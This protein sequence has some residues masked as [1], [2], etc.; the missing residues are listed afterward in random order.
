MGGNRDA[1]AS[2]PSFRDSMVPGPGD[3]RC[4]V[5]ETFA[6]TGEV[7]HSRPLPVRGEGRD[8]F[9]LRPGMRVDWRCIHNV[10]KPMRSNLRRYLKHGILPQLQ[11]FEAVSRYESCTRAADELCMAQPTV[12]VQLRKLT[13]T[14]G[15][16]LFE[17]V[18]RRMCVTEAGH[19]LYSASADIFARLQQL[20]DAFA[21]MRGLRTGSLRLAVGTA[22]KYLAPRMLAG[23][24]NQ[25]PGVEVFLQIHNREMLLRRLAENVD[26]LYIFADP[27]DGEVISQSILPNSMVVFARAD[28]P[29]A[30]Q[31]AIAF[32]RFAEEWFIIREPGSG[33]RML[34]NNIFAA[35]GRKPRVRA[36][37]STNEAIQQGILAGLGVSI[38]SRY[39]LGLDVE[40]K[41]LVALDVEGFPIQC[42][43]CFVYPH[44]KQLSL[45]AQAFMDLVR[46]EARRLIPDHLALEGA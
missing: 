39:A 14:I 35:R 10:T 36:E 43:W 30:Q 25:Y 26:D 34:V 5:S 15:L 1:A 20:E 13:E 42:S 17:Q 23:F 11:V 28:H 41:Q 21:D 22:G 24:L 32:D 4:V 2:G 9:G 27:P 40:Q 18:G 6:Q 7:A 3:N 45:V 8:A 37:L 19:A 44:G 33:T 46:D 29:L 16:P 38:M 31:K 12:S